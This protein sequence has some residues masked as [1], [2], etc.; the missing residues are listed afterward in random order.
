MSLSLCM[1]VKNEAANLPRCLASVVAVVAEIVVVDTGSTDD[2][3]AIAR[4]AGAKVYAWDWTNDFAAARNR[5]LEQVQ[6][7]WVLV[8]DA[9]E[10]LRPEIIPSL[11][12]AIQTPQQLVVNLLRQE[13]G[14]AQAPYSL[15]SRLFRRH[16]ALR[17]E[18]PFHELIDPSVERLLETEPDWQ[19]SYLPEI[20]IDHYGYSATLIQQRQKWQRAQTMMQAYLDQHPE[21]GYVCSKLGGL[22]IQTGELATGLALLQ[23]GLKIVSDPH[24]QYELAYHLGI[25]YSQT[26]QLDLAEQHYYRAV[27]QPIPEILKIGA[28]TNLGCLLQERGVFDA[29]YR[30]F[31][32]VVQQASQFAA[33]Y[34]NLGS[35]LRSLGESGAAIQAYQQ[36]LQLQP[37]YAEAYQNLGAALLYQGQ[38]S[39]SLAA[40]RQAISY[41]E[42]NQPQTAQ[43]LRQRLAEM[44][45]IV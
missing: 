7:D 16:P 40:F 13:I 12:R 34:F 45:L 8:L 20:A 1:I 35:C 39:E 21:D 41:F 15:L 14:A 23:R 19:I 2:T 26:E 36:A 30:Q 42:P 44:G 27:E 11:R 3:V 24:S 33:G 10:A 29:A 17:F 4:Q 37:D 25:A 22:Y 28:R 31:Q 18:R 5:A 43:D 38:V 9:D 6:T 32:L